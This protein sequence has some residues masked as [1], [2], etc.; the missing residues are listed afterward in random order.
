VQKDKEH[1]AL[2]R[3][4]AAQTQRE[5]DREA[6]RL[7]AQLDGLRQELED[8]P[9]KH[10]VTYVDADELATARDERSHAF[11]ARLRS[12]QTL[13]EILTV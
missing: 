13:A 6:G 2:W 12:F 3:A 7:Q 4:L 9:E 1:I 10:I 8:R 5:H 11:R